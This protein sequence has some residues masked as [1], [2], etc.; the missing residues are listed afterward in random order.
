MFVRKRDGRSE[1][2]HFDKITNR[3]S[4]LCWG[5]NSNAVDP[6]IVAQKVIQGL[7]NGVST[8]ELDVLAAETAANM[9]ASAPQYADLAARIAVSNLHKSTHKNFSQV[10][11]DLF[12]YVNPKTKRPA[13]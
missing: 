4:K 8:T 10:A 6:I 11:H 13:G 9:A 7:Y 1:V 12:H 3:I 5:F 2:V